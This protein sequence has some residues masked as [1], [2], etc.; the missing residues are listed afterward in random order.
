MFSLDNTPPPLF[1]L[2][3]TPLLHSICSH[4]NTNPPSPPTFSCDNTSPHPTYFLSQYP[5]P[6]PNLLSWQH[7][8]PPNIFALVT[9]LR[10]CF[11]K[12]TVSVVYYQYSTLASCSTCRSIYISFYSQLHVSCLMDVAN[13]K[14]LLEKLEKTW[15]K[16]WKTCKTWKKNFEA[17]KQIGQGCVWHHEY[18]Y[19]RLEFP[20]QIL[21]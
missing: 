19:M 7:P 16:T 13:L 9:T 15:K 4:N 14:L 8:L 3:T 5:P 21:L 6:P 18:D 10:S 12:Y 17:P 2:T 20:P 1:A 11:N